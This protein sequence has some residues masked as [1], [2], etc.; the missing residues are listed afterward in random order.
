MTT[1]GD[2]DN[3][4]GVDVC[5]GCRHHDEDVH[6]GRAMFEGLVGLDVEVPATEELKE[7]TQKYLVTRH[8]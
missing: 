3:D 2:E 8:I 5:S 4:E 6:V 1:D 7:H